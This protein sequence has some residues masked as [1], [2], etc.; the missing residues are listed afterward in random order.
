MRFY[1]EVIALSEN[2]VEYSFADAIKKFPMIKSMLP[3]K[4]RLELLAD[5]TSVIR[6]DDNSFEI[7]FVGDNNWRIGGQNV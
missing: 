1:C 5:D 4:L 7:G 2:F 6:I 3:L